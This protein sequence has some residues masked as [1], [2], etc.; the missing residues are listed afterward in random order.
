MG[1]LS[2][3]VLYFFKKHGIHQTE[4]T[5]FYFSIEFEVIVLLMHVRLNCPYFL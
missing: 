2:T 1:N 5:K 4:D 3:I